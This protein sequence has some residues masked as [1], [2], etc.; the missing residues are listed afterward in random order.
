[1]IIIE[2]NNTQNRIVLTLT[3]NLDKYPN[4]TNPDNE[5]YFTI[6]ND[7]NEK[8]TKTFMLIDTSLN[9]WRFNEFEVDETDLNLATGTWAYK[10]ELEDYE[11]GYVLEVGRLLVK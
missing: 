5:Y 9:P 1:M 7:F 11:S 2:K 3:E 6:Q 10:V 8:V 4:I